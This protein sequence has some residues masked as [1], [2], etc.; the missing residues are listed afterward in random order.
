MNNYYKEYIKYKEKYRQLKLKDGAF[1][2]NSFFNKDR[3]IEVS[4]SEPWFSLIKNGEKKVEGRLNKGLFERIGV[5]QQITFFNMDRITKQKNT[6][7]CKV[8]DKKPYDTFEEMLEKEGLQNVLP[9][10]SLKTVQDG[11]NVYRR[12]YNET[13]EKQYGVMALHVDCSV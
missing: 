8:V 2:K 13:M 9:D 10:R 7:T 1:N 12:W 3:P 4:L 5:G 6:F 11:V